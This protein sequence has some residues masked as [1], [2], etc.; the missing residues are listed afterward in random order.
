M[1]SPQQASPTSTTQDQYCEPARECFEH[2]VA[3]E[4]LHLE[5]NLNLATLEE[6]VG[7]D[8]AALRRYKV[9]LEAD[10]LHADT[11]VSVALLYEKLEADSLA[12]HHWR[13]YLQLDPGGL[14][15]E[16]ARRHLD[17]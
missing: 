17:R 8:A 7:S 3:I 11:H 14:W 2:A 4:P 6:E 1:K 9:A 16:I 5:A 15:A 13:R 12:R 10:P